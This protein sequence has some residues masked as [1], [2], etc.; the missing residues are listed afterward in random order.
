MYS[1]QA[2]CSRALTDFYK[3]GALPPEHEAIQ[4]SLG[5]FYS[6]LLNGDQT[7]LLHDRGLI[8]TWYCKNEWSDDERRPSQDEVVGSVLSD[9]RSDGARAKPYRCRMSACCF[10]ACCAS[11][12]SCGTVGDTLKSMRSP[13][14]AGQPNMGSAPELVLGN[15]I[16]SR[17]DSEPVR[18]AINRSKPSKSNV[19]TSGW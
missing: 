2:T 15:A 11:G 4:A 3:Y 1:S 13:T 14:G 12:P 5:I 8:D 7:M 16:T 10:C 6:R 18:R 9:V 19:S 17:I